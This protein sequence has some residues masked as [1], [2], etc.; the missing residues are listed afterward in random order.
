MQLVPLH[1][2]LINDDYG[3]AAGG[4]SGGKATPWSYH[5]T[6]E[7]GETAADV[8]LKSFVRERQTEAGSD[9]SAAEADAGTEVGL[10]HVESS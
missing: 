3:K 9:T 6:E 10:V 8:F 7:T 2:G 4:G 5:A 1:L